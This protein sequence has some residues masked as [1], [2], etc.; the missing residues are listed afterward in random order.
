M[1]IA[2]VGRNF[3]GKTTWAICTACILSA[4]AVAMVA[5]IWR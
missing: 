1:F 4:A 3:D 5:G 2:G